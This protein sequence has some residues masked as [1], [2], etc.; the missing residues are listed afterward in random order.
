MAKTKAYVTHVWCCQ[1][2][3]ITFSHILMLSRNLQ[4]LLDISLCVHTLNPPPCNVA[5]QIRFSGCFMFSPS[6][7]ITSQVSPICLLSMTCYKNLIKTY[8]LKS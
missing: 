6:V 7:K 5:S 8:K 4:C 2:E 3:R 1:S